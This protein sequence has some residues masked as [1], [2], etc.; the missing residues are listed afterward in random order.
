MEK[1]DE[2]RRRSK[3]HSSARSEWKALSLQEYR[4]GSFRDLKEARTLLGLADART[5]RKYLLSLEIPLYRH[6]L[7]GNFAL[8]RDE[9][10]HAIAL[11]THRS[12]VDSTPSRSRV[13]SSA[14]TS[15]AQRQLAELQV[16][17]TREMVGIESRIAVLEE[18]R[19]QEAQEYERRIASL[20]AEHDRIVKQL[21]D[22]L[23]LFQDRLREATRTS[24]TGPARES[25]ATVPRLPKG[26]EPLEAFARSHQVGERE[27]ED[28][29][30]MEKIPIVLGAWRRGGEK[31]SRALDSEG[32]AAFYEFFHIS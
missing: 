24:R 23:Q 19:A 16:Q 6:P 18:L 12:R 29:V 8:I 13:A 9:D 14:G 11:H 27:L 26:L 5:L 2:T 28:A 1:G 30:R 3:N 32:Q 7:N 31:I 10:L 25:K 22:R 20:T 17:Y 21:R 4:N 15:D